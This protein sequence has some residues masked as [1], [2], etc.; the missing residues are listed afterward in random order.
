MEGSGEIDRD[1]LMGGL[2]VDDEQ[3]FTAEVPFTCMYLTNGEPV[4]G[5]LPNKVRA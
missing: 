5:S 3:T 2:P 1:R 4:T